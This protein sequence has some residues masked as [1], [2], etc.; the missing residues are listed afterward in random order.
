MIRSLIK[1]TYLL[2]IAL[3]IS[4]CAFPQ[5]NVIVGTQDI[6][7]GDDPSPYTNY[8]RY[9]RVQF[10]YT[11]AEINSALTAAGLGTGTARDIQAVSWDIISNHALMELTNYSVK[12]GHTTASDASSHNSDAS[13]TV[14]AEHTFSPS[15]TG[16]Q[17]I[18]FDSNFAWDGTSNIVFDICWSCSYYSVGASIYLFNDV[19]DQMAAVESDWSEQCSNNIT[20]TYNGKPRIRFTFECDPITV[21]VGSDIDI[22]NTSTVAALSGNNPASG[23]T[24]K[25]TVVSGAGT[26]TDDTDYDTEV[27]SVGQGENIYRW[28]VTNTST[29][30]SDYADLT[31]N[32]NTPTTPDAGTD[33]GSCN[34]T[35]QLEANIPI[36][37]T[38]L[39]SVTAGTG[40]FDDNTLYNTNVSNM[41]GADAGT[42]NTFTWTITNNG[43]SL[44]DDVTITYYLP[45]VASV[46]S[47]PLTDCYASETLTLNGNNPA[48]LTPA[49]T[50]EWTVVSGSGTFADET[51]Y[52][53]TVTNV[54]TPTNTYRWTLSRNGCISSANLVVNNSSPSAA[55]AGTDQTISSSTTN[56][57]G[58]TPNQGTGTWS[59]LPSGP[60]IVSPNDPN[61]EVTGISENILYTFT[62]TISS[63]TCANT[64][65]EVT[66]VRMPGVL[67]FI[68]Q[69]DL[70]NNGS[71]IQTDEDNFFIMNGAG[72]YINGGTASTNTYT[73]AKVR[74]MGIIEFDGEIDNGKFEKT[75][76][77]A[78]GTLTI[79]NA[80]TYKNHDLANYG[81]LSLFNSSVFE[82]SGDWTN[83][84]SFL[85]LS[86]STVIF[87]GDELQTV[88]TNSTGAADQLCNVEIAQTVVSP[89]TANGVSIQ[90]PFWMMDGVTLTLTNGVMVL[91][92]G[93]SVVIIQ[94][95]D[96]DAV[97]GNFD[98]SWVYAPNSPHHFE[99]FM[100]DVSNEDY[101]FPLGGTDKPNIAILNNRELPDGLFYIDA[102]FIESPA[103]VNTNFPSN[104]TEGDIMYTQVSDYGIWGLKPNGSFDGF[105]DLDLNIENF[106]LTSANDNL[107]CILKRP[108][109]SVDG[110]TWSIPTGSTFS[111]QVVSGGYAVREDISTFSE[112]GIGLGFSTLPVEL[113]DFK[114]KCSNSEVVISWT[115][116]SETNNDYF[117]LERSTD[118]LSFEE[119]AR[120]NGAG[121][122]N[123]QLS[124]SFV[125]EGI[126]QNTTYFYRLRQTDFDGTSVT[127]KPV[128][129]SCD[130][131][132]VDC[133]FAVYPNPFRSHLFINSICDGA[134]QIRVFDA[135][136]AV[137]RYDVLR[138]LNTEKIDLSELEPGL[139][140]IQIIDQ[141]GKQHNF[142]VE[143]VI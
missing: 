78:A 84:L 50:G 87:N 114:A 86:T 83:E 113:L 76:I 41:T 24:G 19:A 127:F 95:D 128:Y 16:W 89:S 14:K 30:C 137:V 69:E 64:S 4:V 67:G 112:F 42:A 88:T 59:V 140:Y 60:T 46:T 107:Y 82:N 92:D 98:Q 110:S 109:G 23:H 134:S 54:G 122:S 12:M 75:E 106:G 40:V 13:T 53:T 56:L 34:A 116:V 103:A 132:I 123:S 135:R 71:F 131:E 62:W 8:Y 141:N 81:V 6:S 49:A 18:D 1:N 51:A 45:P 120:I 129:V 35:Y 44:S 21:S 31:V 85:A 101:Y 48:S 138:D 26:F 100:D 68:I 20:N 93:T 142:K 33:V 9:Y 55:T 65:D 73:D 99:R 66:V 17:Q 38:G 3:L 91:G 7:S 57:Q 94:N 58:N 72:K 118:A 52:N 119:I 27:S 43:C 104:L 143:K 117:T 97:T 5:L 70:T 15:G 133:Q 136:G 77:T 130:E 32:N 63:G 125:D 121:N 96:S 102:Y 61:S 105:Y 139:Y 111:A 36:Y 11:A 79:N 22:C 115:T 80:R 74:V 90:D 28:T 37:G 126:M 39:W 25:W 47:S 124:Y 2:I 10:V 29:G 108:I